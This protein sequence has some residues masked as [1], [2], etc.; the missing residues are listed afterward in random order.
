MAKNSQKARL[1][2]VLT[3]SAMALLILMVS[4]DSLRG[5][6]VRLQMKNV[7]L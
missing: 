2:N 5:T 6:K 7:Q 4:K 3:Q 1:L